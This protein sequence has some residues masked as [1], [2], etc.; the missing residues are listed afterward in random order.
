MSS[1][2]PW[3]KAADCERAIK[4][5]ANPEQRRLLANLRDLWIA[6]GR[7]CELMGSDEI[8]QQAEVIG[9]LHARLYAAGDH[10][11]HEPANPFAAHI[12]RRA[13]HALAVAPFDLR[14]VRSAVNAGRRRY[15]G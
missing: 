3:E 1:I 15:G 11:L 2:D 12:D 6:L 13:E 4:S 8:A 9:R 7:Q 5:A 14:A 10:R